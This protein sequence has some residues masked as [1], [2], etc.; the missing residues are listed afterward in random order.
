[1]QKLLEMMETASGYVDGVVEGNTKADDETGRRIADT[2]ASV[3]RIRPE[4]F[5]VWTKRRGVCVP[6]RARRPFLFLPSY[7]P[8]NDPKWAEGRAARLH[9]FTV[10]TNPFPF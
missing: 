7:Q 9:G 6:P 2:L 10:P 8:T 5:T 4:V 3:P 1:M